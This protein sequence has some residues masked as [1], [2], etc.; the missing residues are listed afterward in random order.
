MDTR[1]WGSTR[2]ALPGERGPGSIPVRAHHDATTGTIWGPEHYRCRYGSDD[3]RERGTCTRTRKAQR[4][5]R[6]SC[7]L[8]SSSPPKITLRNTA[9]RKR[10][11]ARR[12]GLAPGLPVLET[13]VLAA[14]PSTQTVAAVTPGDGRNR[15]G[16][17]AA[18]STC[19]P[20][21]RFVQSEQQL[22]HRHR[23]FM[24]LSGG[25]WAFIEYPRTRLRVA[26]V[27]AERR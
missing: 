10:M 2:P 24:R 9:V 23:M 19:R 12:P 11:I 18:S 13:G 1:R 3:G 27:P 6:A 22:A 5:L 7:L 26:S 20:C 14:R 16:G 25:V 8:D 4:F 15:S 17:S 21:A